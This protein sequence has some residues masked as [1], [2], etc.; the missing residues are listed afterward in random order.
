M[1]RTYFPRI[2]VPFAGFGSVLLEVAALTVVFLI[3][4]AHALWVGGPAP[5]R[6]GW[7]TLWL[8]PALLGALLFALAI[9]SVLGIVALFFRDVIY[10]VGFMAQL[11]MLA[12]PVLYPVTFVSAPYRWVVYVLNPMAQIVMLSR[13]ALTGQGGF[14][15]LFVA[16]SFL[17]ILLVFAACVTFFLRAEMHLGDQL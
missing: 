3:V 11:F 12:T 14:D 7:Q 4:V 1:Q 9:G 5:V 10:S 8:I 16:L 6:F 15:P 2:L 13:W 17:T